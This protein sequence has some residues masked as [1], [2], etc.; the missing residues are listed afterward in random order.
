MGFQAVNLSACDKVI[1]K[2][3]LEN[4]T[5]V[6]ALEWINRRL[7]L[8]YSFWADPEGEFHWYPEDLDQE[9]ETI[10][11]QGE[12]VLEWERIANGRRL[13]TV[14]GTQVWHSQVIE[15][16]AIGGVV[17]RYFVEQVRHTVGVNGD[18][19]RTMLWLRELE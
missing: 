2:L 4:D 16:D 8:G 3:P 10:F 1:D 6:S 5:I 14:M 19:L 7:A 12:D 9:A 11:T 13:L 18:G 17:T 15:F